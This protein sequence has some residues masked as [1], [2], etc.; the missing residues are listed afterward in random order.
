MKN[1]LLEVENEYNSLKSSAEQK[2]FLRDPILLCLLKSTEREMEYIFKYAPKTEDE[3]GYTKNLEAFE[4]VVKAVK[5]STVAEVTKGVGVN[6]T[7]GVSSGKPVVNTEVK[8]MIDQKQQSQERADK[9]R[10]LYGL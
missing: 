6:G 1:I 7:A 3:E 2:R 8:A 10:E 9:A 4:A 5:E